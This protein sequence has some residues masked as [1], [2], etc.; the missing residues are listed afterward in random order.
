MF[1]PHF[2]LKYFTG[3]KEKEFPTFYLTGSY[4]DCLGIQAS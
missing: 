1:I 4:D 3:Y 2:D